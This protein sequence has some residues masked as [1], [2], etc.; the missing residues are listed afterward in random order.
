MAAA[1]A[2]NAH[3]IREAVRELFQ[4]HLS[5]IEA[6]DLEVGV[7]NA[8]IDL[9]QAHPF[10][11]S[12]YNP[13]FQEA[14]LARARS[15]LVNMD[16]RSYVQNARL[17]AR[18]SEKEFLPHEMASMAP[19]NL[20]PEAWDDVI[21]AELRQMKGAFEA[22]MAAMTDIYTCSKCKKKRCSY[23]ELQTRSADE[24][25]TTFVRCLNCGHR[26]KH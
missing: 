11:A 17:S 22:N 18:L 21:Q 19:E 20:C 12:W 4:Q 7:F 16:P 9:A 15:M 8:A 1:P 26:W 23:Y 25:A 13:L 2:I 10:A 14:Y 6:A 3:P 5:D 24:P